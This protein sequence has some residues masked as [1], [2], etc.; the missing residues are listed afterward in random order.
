M[1]KVQ[2]GS[3]VA[4]MSGRIAGTVHARNKGGSYVRRFSV[5]VN[6]S[7][8][9]Q[10]NIRNCLSTISSAWRNLT[11]PDQSAWVS[12]AESHPVID[13]LGAAIKLSGQQAFVATNRNG[14]SNG[15]G[16]IAFTTP[17]AEPQYEYPL[18][19]D[20]T[21]TLDTAVGTLNIT[22]TVQPA[23]DTQLLIYATAA[24]SPGISFAKGRNKFLGA[25]T[26]LQA[27]AVPAQIDITAPWITRFGSITPSQLGKKVIIGART[28][29]NG[30]GSG[31][32]GS[33]G[34][35]V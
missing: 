10:Q 27:T 34:L 6:P 9:F 28:Y 35:G 14:F 8:S 29:S 5:P 15:D 32:V 4:Y 12:W 20:F 26:V 25:I 30:Q 18:E 19:P 16:A 11:A 23:A 33:F 1:A 2:F 31:S 21:V 7:T 13:R 24:L 22:Q 17:P 3:G